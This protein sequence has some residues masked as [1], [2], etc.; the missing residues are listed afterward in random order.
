MINKQRAERVYLYNLFYYNQLQ[1][2]LDTIEES[3]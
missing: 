2:L 3:P 1:G